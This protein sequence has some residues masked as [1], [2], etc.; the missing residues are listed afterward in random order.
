MGE[1]KRGKRRREGG[2]LVT[3]PIVRTLVTDPK[4]WDIKEEPPPRSGDDPDPNGLDS[5]SGR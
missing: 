1:P 4:P 3:D 5:D 2:K